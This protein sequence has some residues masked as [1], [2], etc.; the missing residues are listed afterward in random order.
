MKWIVISCILCVFG[1]FKEFRPSESF[2]TD[3]F[4]GPWKNFT[5]V[6]VNHEI[7]PV[8]TYSYFATLIVVFLIT[9]FVQYKPVII[10]CGLSGAITYVLIIFGKNLLTMQIM[11][12]F[13]GLFFS[14]EVAYYTYIYAKVDK[15]HYQEVTSH[16]KAASLFGRCMSGIIAQLTVSFDMLDYHQLNYLTLSAVTFAMIWAFFLPPVG[17]SI[18]FHRKNENCISEVTI[19]TASDQ[20]LTPVP[21]LSEDHIQFDSS[22]KK[23]SMVKKV[24]LAYAL[25][26][27][28]FLEAYSNG[29]IVKWSLWCSFSTCGYLQVTGYIQ[30]LWQTA[31]SPQDKIYNGAVE[32][33]YTIIGTIT[34]FCIGKVPFNWS[35]IGAVVVSFMSFMEGI[36]LVVSSYSYNIWLLYLSFIV[37][38]IIYHTMITV[39]SFEVAKNISEDSYGLVFG[40]NTFLALALQS[41]LTA[42]VL[43]ENLGLTLRCQ[44]FIYGGYFI[45]IAMLYIIVGIFNIVRHYKSG[46]DFNIWVKNKEAVTDFQPKMEEKY[47]E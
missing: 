36:L 23:V 19:E 16:T 41:I 44:Y 26:W 47:L 30:L 5:S 33:L 28:D 24:R 43:N 15:E 45:V 11:E 1:C 22:N 27:K 31:V 35:L 29:H 18:Y 7:F 21:Q 6:Q 4:T 3:Y 40:I 37:F 10:L 20:Q 8:S 2:V 46:N 9:D 34:V 17:K 25:L 39:A 12:F 42:I 13:Y 14:T 32:A 38:G